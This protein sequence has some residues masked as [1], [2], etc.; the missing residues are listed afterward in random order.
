[1]KMNILG[2]I[3]G[4]KES[5]HFSGAIKKQ[6]KLLEKL[7]SLNNLIEISQKA[8]DAKLNKLKTSDAK[9]TKLSNQKEDLEKLKTSLNETIKNSTGE[10]H[11][12]SIDTQDLNQK[13]QT[14]Q[15]YKKVTKDVENIQKLL[16]KNNFLKNDLIKINKS[17][18]EFKLSKERHI[19]LEAEKSINRDWQF[20]KTHIY[21]QPKFVPKSDYN[22]TSFP[23]KTEKIEINP[24]LSTKELVKQA[25]AIE[26]YCKCVNEY[27]E[28]FSKINR[29]NNEIG[30]H[31]KLVKKA[32]SQ[33]PEERK[34]YLFS[35]TKE[36][37]KVFN[38]FLNRSSAVESKDTKITNKVNSNFDRDAFNRNPVNYSTLFN[39]EL[40][41]LSKLLK[42]PEGKSIFDEAK[43]DQ[44]TRNQ[45]IDAGLANVYAQKID[46]FKKKYGE[47]SETGQKFLFE[48]GKVCKEKG[49][50]CTQ[51]KNGTWVVNGAGAHPVIYPISQ[52]IFMKFKMHLKLSNN[53]TKMC[54]KSIN[55]IT[56]KVYKKTD[57]LCK[58]ENRITTSDLRSLLDD[59]EKKVLDGTVNKVN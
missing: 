25:Q 58:Q 33:L 55:Y 32:F 13:T 45:L 1:M 9:H 6:S 14:S 15:L 53:K 30:S 48:I 38:Q 8:I 36:E 24:E 7:V 26:K 46:D 37:M 18:D 4:T 52:N 3:F 49:V 11:N 31:L 56:N 34:N 47:S 21:R 22:N 2:N 54:D 44:T 35:L 5:Y 39:S 17:F 50:K 19:R 16:N 29:S 41:K 10:E 57:E 51:N 43:Y 20:I 40:L 42:L 59:V 12:S 28:C 27:Y 23:A